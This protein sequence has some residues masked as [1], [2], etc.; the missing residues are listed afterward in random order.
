[1]LIPTRFEQ[2]P[3][4][5]PLNPI[6]FFHNLAYSAQRKTRNGLLFQ[7]AFPIVGRQ[8]EDKLEI[9]A[10]AERVIQGRLPSR[11]AT[12]R[13]ASLIGMASAN[14]KPRSRFPRRCDA[15]PVQGRR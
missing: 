9:L 4:P 11:L 10:I 12:W 5:L 1:M 13:A 3:L 15:G 8:R 7:Q 6:A 2:L 14:S